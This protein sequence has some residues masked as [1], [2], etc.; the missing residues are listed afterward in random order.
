[1]HRVQLEIIKIETL[2]LIVLLTSSSLDGRP[3]RYSFISGFVG[4]AIASTDRHPSTVPSTNARPSSVLS[5]AVSSACTLKLAMISASEVLNRKFQVR[6]MWPKSITHI[7]VKACNL[8][9]AQYFLSV[10]TS[11]MKSTHNF[12]I[13]ILDVFRHLNI[14]IKYSSGMIYR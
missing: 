1:M 14:Y 9:Y 7:Y 2:Y 12:S 4:S 11:L 5:I 8:L 10:K 3:A 13:F 6:T